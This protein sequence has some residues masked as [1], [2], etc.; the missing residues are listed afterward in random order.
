MS[1]C[2]YT[3]FS[4]CVYP[5]HQQLIVTLCTATVWTSITSPGF[6]YQQTQLLHFPQLL[7]CAPFP[8]ED[9]WRLRAAWCMFLH[10]LWGG[11]VHWQLHLS[12]RN[13]VSGRGTQIQEESWIRYSCSLVTQ[14]CVSCF[15]RQLAI[16]RWVPVLNFQLWCHH[17]EKKMRGSHRIVFSQSKELD[18]SF[19]LKFF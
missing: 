11:T 18:K 9:S 12:S 10:V 15:G 7:H 2:T 3:L 16:F 5:C 17:L 8:L 13:R 1:S 14:V 19:H 6:W 4:R